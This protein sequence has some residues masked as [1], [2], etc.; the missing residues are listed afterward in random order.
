MAS[1]TWAAMFV[2]H[3]SVKQLSTCHS[4]VKQLS[5][6]H[7]IPVIHREFDWDFAFTCSWIFRCFLLLFHSFFSFRCQ[8]NK[9]QY[10]YTH[11]F[12]H[13]SC[14][15]STVQEE[16][17]AHTDVR[18]V[19]TCNL[20]MGHFHRAEFQPVC[21]DSPS[22]LAVSLQEGSRHPSCIDVS[23]TICAVSTKHR[24]P[25]RPPFVMAIGRQSVR[26]RSN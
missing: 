6:C 19:K 22:S 17:P 2:F 12:I 7:A 10:I 1:Q 5:T 25:V 14:R 26:G 15:L 24:H 23:S 4:S 21:T 18:F 16:L 11:T 8:I 13:T 20:L 3:S 9:M